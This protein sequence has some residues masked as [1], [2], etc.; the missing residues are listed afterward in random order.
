MFAAIM[1]IKFT[2]D[3]FL[4]ESMRK[5]NEKA[6]DQLF[7]KYYTGLLRYCSMLLP[8]P[9]DEAEE[10]ILD[11]FANLWNQRKTL[12]LHTSL[13]SFLYKSV[14]NRVYDYYRKRNIAATVSVE[15]AENEPE[16]AHLI[17]DHQLVFKE[18]TKGIESLISLLPQRT[19][20]VFRMNRQE[21]L[22]YQ[23]IATLLNISANSVKTHMYRALK[24]MKDAYQAAKASGEC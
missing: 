7:Q 13:A 1:A 12:Q 2:E 4:L 24:F 21:D 8:Y 16:Q 14:K 20:L 10:V 3:S 19:Q 6:F 5:G 15:A 18:L 11:V 9:S 17:P 22:S 23:E